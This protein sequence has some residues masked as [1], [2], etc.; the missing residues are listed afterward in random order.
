MK[1]IHR[2]A[3]M[4]ALAFGVAAFGC[5]GANKAKD[6]GTAATTGGATGQGEGRVISKEAKKDFDK[7]AER[8]KEAEKVG[9]N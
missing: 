3:W 7:A 1:A 4:L 5:G 2:Y 6:S 9:W 8:F